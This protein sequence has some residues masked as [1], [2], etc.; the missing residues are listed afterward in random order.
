MRKRG[1]GLGQEGRGA[2]CEGR[3]AEITSPSLLCLP[4]VVS[5]SHPAHAPHLTLPPSLPS[6]LSCSLAPL[7]ILRT[8]ASPILAHPSRLLSQLGALVALYA[9]HL[10]LTPFLPLLPLF[11]PLCRSCRVPCCPRR[12][13]QG[14]K[15][16]QGGSG[17]GG[18]GSARS[19]TSS[20]CCGASC[21]SGIDLMVTSKSVTTE[22][23]GLLQQGRPQV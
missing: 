12:Q 11:P 6:P 9:P 14:G 5:L 18:G 20:C 13:A 22:T 16:G 15:G 8:M 23:N 19:R 4:P 3:A 17:K 1:D 2:E 21:R 10:A 7:C